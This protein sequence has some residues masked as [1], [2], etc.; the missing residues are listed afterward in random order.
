M[1]RLWRYAQPAPKPKLQGREGTNN[2]TL[3]GALTCSDSVIRSK[4]PDA[5]VAMECPNMDFI[6]SCC[7][8]HELAVGQVRTIRS[9]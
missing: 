9:L 5:L 2:V 8:P 4:V 1:R 7:A 6:V 3:Y